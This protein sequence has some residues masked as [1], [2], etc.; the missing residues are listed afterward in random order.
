[1]DLSESIQHSEGEAA[2][3]SRQ[4]RQQ[5]TTARNANTLLTSS[6][7]HERNCCLEGPLSKTSGTLNKIFRHQECAA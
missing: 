6:N 5:R 4:P 2:E 1:M 7:R 3:T